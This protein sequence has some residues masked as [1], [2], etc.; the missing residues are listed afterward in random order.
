M[1]HIIYYKFMYVFTWKFQV[2][3]SDE[4]LKEEI[5]TMPITHRFTIIANVWLKMEMIIHLMVSFKL[6]FFGHSERS[7]WGLLTN[8]LPNKLDYQL[9]NLI[10]CNFRNHET[11]N[12]Q[13]RSVRN[14]STRENN[15]DKNE[16]ESCHFMHYNVPAT[17]APQ[18]WAVA[19]WFILLVVTGKDP[20]KNSFLEFF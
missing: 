3:M 12:H 6:S 11:F 10:I 18:T 16:Y 5:Q 19:T 13:L 15:S 14:G 9:L 4:S 1:A 7:H 20:L 17:D 2:G 8:E